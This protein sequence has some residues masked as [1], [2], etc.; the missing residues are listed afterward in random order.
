MLNRQ[1]SMLAEKRQQIDSILSAIDRAASEV[2]SGRNQWDAIVGVIEVIQMDQTEQ[3]VKKYFTDEQLA[4]MQDLGSRSYSPEAQ[5]KLAELQKLTP[6]TEDD[7]ARV[8][9]QWQHVF[10]ESERLA[11]AGADPAGDEAQAVAKLKTDLLSAFTQNDPEIAAGLRKFWENHKELPSQKQPL[12]TWQ[13]AMTGAGA[14]LLD[15]AMEIY[16]ELT[17]NR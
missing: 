16:A 2:Q 1:R 4:E 15:R 10:D 3:W 9:A 6:W 14:Q 5:Q 11:T 13:A 12:A 8:S 7:Q 17:T